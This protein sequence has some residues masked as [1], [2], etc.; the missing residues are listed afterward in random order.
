MIAKLGSEHLRRAY[1]KVIATSTQGFGE[2]EESYLSK[3]FGLN[4]ID[5]TENRQLGMIG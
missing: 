2:F 5:F 3:L 4:G 1:P